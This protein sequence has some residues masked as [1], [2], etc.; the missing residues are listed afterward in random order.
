[1]VYIL[2]SLPFKPKEERECDHGHPPPV[3][4]MGVVRWPWPALYRI[5]RCPS[6]LK[7][8]ESMTMGITPISQ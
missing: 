4:N 6:R 1:M 3:S 5:G 7:K 8:V 2:R